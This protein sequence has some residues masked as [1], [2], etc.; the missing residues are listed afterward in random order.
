M[1]PA[2]AVPITDVCIIADLK[3]LPAG[4]EVVS[5]DCGLHNCLY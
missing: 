5:L 1:P 2:D 4:F 3:R